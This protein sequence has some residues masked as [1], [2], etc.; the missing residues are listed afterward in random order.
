MAQYQD[1]VHSIRGPKHTS[2]LF[3]EFTEARCIVRRT[4]CIYFS[5]ASPQ[6]GKYTREFE[7]GCFA[8][9]QAADPNLLRVEV[10]RCR[11]IGDA[12]CE[13]H[14]VYSEDATT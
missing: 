3:A 14:W 2:A 13:Q 9:Y 5:D 8:G 12:E 6:N 10:L 7:R 1:L 11:C 4:E